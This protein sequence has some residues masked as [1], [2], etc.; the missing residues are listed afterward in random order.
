MKTATSIIEAG[1]SRLKWPSVSK[2]SGNWRRPK[3]DSWLRRCKKSWIRRERG[4]KRNRRSK[5]LKS[6]CSWGNGQNW[7]SCP[8]MTIPRTYLTPTADRSNSQHSL[9]SLKI[10]GKETS[11]M[12]WSTKWTSGSVERKES[13]F[14]R[15]NTQL[16]SLK[17]QRRILVETKFLVKSFSRLALKNKTMTR[18]QWPSQTQGWAVKWRPFEVS[19]LRRCSRRSW[20]TKQ[21]R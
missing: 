18:K 6:W 15:R 3:N 10:S 2:L 4:L 21:L 5:T 16:S 17:T 11:A 12:N 20:T 19:W 13:T 1:K 7:K 14:R 9:K 8:W